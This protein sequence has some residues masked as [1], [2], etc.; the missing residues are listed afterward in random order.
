MPIRSKN[1][2][3][4]CDVIADALKKVRD[5]INNSAVKTGRNPE[6]IKLIAVSKTVDLQKIIEAVKAGAALLGENRVQE[7]KTKITE[8]RSQNTDLRPEWHLI[9]N[10]QKNKAKNAVQLFDVIHSLDSVE[11][12][13]AL[14][15]YSVRTGK[16]QRVLI[17]VKL[18][19]ETAKHG[20]VERGFMQL[21]EKTSEMENIKLE[22]LMTIPPF[23]DEI[24]KTRPYFRKLRELRDKLSS[25]G[26]ILPELSMGMSNDF[27][28]AIEE[29]ATMVRVGTAIFGERDY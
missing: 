8:L 16:K 22:G 20:I 6:E 1:A 21:I 3:L 9:G 12:A 29:G 10:L 19:D 15:K 17:Q 24:E 25:E 4:L 27:E 14:N 7:A 23:F 26:F 11:L 5:R 28:V 18:S 13:E 2:K